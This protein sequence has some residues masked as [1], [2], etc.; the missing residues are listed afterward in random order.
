MSR[1]VVRFTRP[2]ERHPTAVC[3]HFPSTFV[4]HKFVLGGVK[5]RIHLMTGNTVKSILF[6][7]RNVLLDSRGLDSRWIITLA[8]AKTRYDLLSSYTP[9]VLHWRV[10]TTYCRRSTATTRSTSPIRRPYT[11]TLCPMRM[12]LPPPMRH[13]LSK[14]R[15]AA[16]R[17]DERKATDRWTD[18]KVLQRNGIWSRN[19]QG[20]AR[21]IKKNY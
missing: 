7:E 13:L 11:V 20:S 12:M 16:G 4:T 1:A 2:P 15:M 14:I 5:E 9:G 6:V 8:T 18:T 3:F 10:M 19:I 21:L 17:H